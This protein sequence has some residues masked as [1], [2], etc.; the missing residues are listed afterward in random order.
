MRALCLLGCLASLSAARAQER[1]PTP[2]LETRWRVAVDGGVSANAMTT[3]GSA[4][5]ERAWR[6]PVFL[7]A[8]AWAALDPDGGF[9]D[10]GPSMTGGGGEAYAV[11]STRD[12]WIDLR[13]GVGVGLAVLDYGRGGLGCG[14]AFEACAGGTSDAFTGA[15]PYLVGVVGLDLY[16]HRAVGLGVDVRPALMRGPANVSTVALGLRARI[17]G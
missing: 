9:V 7:G 10:D 6:G 4:S 12:R 16:P 2:P 14:P 15:R 17:G 3:V 5:L 8:R 11:A 13:A 1:A